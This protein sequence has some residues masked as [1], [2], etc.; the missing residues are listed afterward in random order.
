M[1]RMFDDMENSLK[2]SEITRFW[3]ASPAS[4][5]TFV[6]EFSAVYGAIA[7]FLLNPKQLI[8]FGGTVAA[9]E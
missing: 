2:I 8:V 9:A 3:T 7:Q 6:L 4:R 5:A 1:E